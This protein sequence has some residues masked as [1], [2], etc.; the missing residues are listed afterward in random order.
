MTLGEAAEKVDKAR[1]ELDDSRQKL[2]I[3]LRAQKVE[4]ELEHLKEKVYEEYGEHIYCIV[5]N[6][7]SR[8][9]SGS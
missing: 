3:S 9:L 2:R 7:Y 6:S 8:R 5:S 4:I 1:T